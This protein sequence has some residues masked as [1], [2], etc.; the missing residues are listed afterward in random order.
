MIRNI[1]QI[2]ETT[3]Q[4]SYLAVPP[5]LREDVKKWGYAA[6]EFTDN[7]CWPY[8]LYVR[9]AR[10]MRGDFVMTEHDV[11]KDKIKDDVIAMGSYNIDSHNVQRYMTLD[12]FVLNEGEIQIPVTPYQIP[13]RVM[14]P[15]RNQADNLLVTV[16]VSATHIAYSSL[17]M[18]PQYM[19]MGEAA[20]IAASLSVKQSADVQNIDIEK[21]QQTLIENGAVFKTAE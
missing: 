21:L 13:Y 2:T 11:R 10:R 15:K 6:D 20:G 9:E 7:G 16:C 5:E 1:H 19:M 12:G 8:Q 17:R 14:L 3:A 4:H 18:E